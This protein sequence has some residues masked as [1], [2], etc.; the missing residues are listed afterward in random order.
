MRFADLLRGRGY[1]IL[2]LLLTLAIWLAVGL[3]LVPLHD[4]DGSYTSYP[5]GL[6]TGLENRSLDLL[7]Q[8]RRSNPGAKRG[9]KEPV[10]ILGVDEEAIQAMGVRAQHWPRS[11]YARLV[12]AAHRGGATV[13][14]LDVLL[15][16]ESGASETARAQ[17]RALV[18]ALVRAGN[19]VIAE[20]SAS[21]GTPVN[22]APVFAEAAW[23]TGFIDLPL[24]SDG[25]V[26]SAAVRLFSPEEQTWK[27]SFAARLA[28]GHRMALLYEAFKQ[29]RLAQGMSE[30]EAAKA[31]TGASL[32]QETPDGALR[33][34]E[35]RLPLRSDGHMQLDFRG[36]P[37]AFRYLSAASILQSGAEANVS[38]RDC[39][40]IIAQTSAVSG[41]SFPTPFFETGTLARL[42]GPPSP[43]APVRTSGAEIHATTVAT[44]LHGVPPR[45]PGL[46][47]QMLFLL[48]PLLP[49]AWAVFRFRAW[50]AMGSILALAGAALLICT[51]SFGA[52]AS[53][54]PLASS[55]LG[56]ALLAPTGMGLRHARERSL[57]DLA[58]VERAQLMDIFS[59]CVS[60]GVAET[61]W[62]QRDQLGLQGERRVVT[63]IFTDI[64]DFTTLSESSSSE[65]VVAWL[66]E[67]FA[68]MNT[69][70][71]GAGGHISKFIGDGL[72]IVFGAPLGRGERVE[73]QGAVAC[74]LAMLEEVARINEDWRGTSRPTLRIG[75][76]IHTG[77][78]TCGVVG[79]PQRMEY[80]V[81][82]DT[83]N[84][85]SR[86]ESKTKELGVPLLLS[87][88]TA[89]RLEE[90][91]LLR[92]LGEIEVKGKSQKVSVYTTSPKAGGPDV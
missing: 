87:E 70:V 14:G 15:A 54:L 5:Y 56:L 21:G 58:E 86:L 50:L 85:A 60:P 78:A 7:F 61:L 3:A 37:P 41:D 24:D 67:Y 34:G 23:A 20:K 59:R 36:R 51:W 39:I 89:R 48:I 82:G 71:T 16:G 44:L 57:R 65:E 46:W 64:R 42:L 12:D 69:V 26:R 66:T 8:L 18:E 9:T 27:W 55:W 38:F 40:V 43:S 73:A 72:M 30:A 13:I 49:G 91:F 88:E 81:I 19:V 11:F 84:L 25:F 80:T 75:V 74:G 47:G 6:A 53:V 32:L 77:E 45:R 90:V 22:P 52:Q 68:R 10:V 35:L 83:I 28:E 63:V 31:A 2:A 92:S 33:C 29:E 79:S 17:D 76:G 4:A 62:A 1:G